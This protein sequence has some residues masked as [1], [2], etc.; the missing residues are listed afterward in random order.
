[1]IGQVMEEHDRSRSKSRNRKRRAK[2]REK[3]I[4]ALSGQMNMAMDSLG[5]KMSR[6]SNINRFHN[7]IHQEQQKFLD[8]QKTRGGLQAFYEAGY[9]SSYSQPRY[10]DIFPVK[11]S[12]AF[13]NMSSYN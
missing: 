11:N 8:G 13:G 1:M 10:E 7:Q 3:R 2:N 4:M 12:A 9:R 5:K 6:L